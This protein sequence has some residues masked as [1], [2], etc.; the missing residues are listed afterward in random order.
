MP[1]TV[2]SKSLEP[3]TFTVLINYKI[4]RDRI[5]CKQLF[6]RTIS[7]IKGINVAMQQLSL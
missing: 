6:K 4:I 5:K 1:I 2:Y 7:Q 3:N